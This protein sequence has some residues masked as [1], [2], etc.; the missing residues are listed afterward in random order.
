MTYNGKILELN[1]DKICFRDFNILK[2]KDEVEGSVAL[3]SVKSTDK[4]K[5]THA[6][7]KPNLYKEFS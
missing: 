2:N 7:T 4:N 1:E 3:K 5:V 6:I